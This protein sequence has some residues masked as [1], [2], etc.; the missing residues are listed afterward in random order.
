MYGA[1]VVRANP[2]EIALELVDIAGVKA[3]HVDIDAKAFSGGVKIKHGR[4][5]MVERVAEIN[6]PEISE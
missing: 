6:D 1:K 5:V 4:S 3:G 2:F